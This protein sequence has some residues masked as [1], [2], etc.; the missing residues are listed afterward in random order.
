MLP[1]NHHN[2]QQNPKRVLVKSCFA[3]GDLIFSVKTDPE[4]LKVGDVISFVEGSIVVTH[5]IVEVQSA[6]N[7]TIKWITKGD[8]NNTEDIR[9]VYE[10]NLVGKYVTHIP[11]LGSFALFMQ[12]PLGMILFIGVPLLGFIIYDIIRRQHYANKERQKTADMQA[13]IDRLR[14]LAGE[15]HSSDFEEQ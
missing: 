15:T 5:R 12:T 10:A 3:A 13:E 9:P 14:A 2:R 4:K 11:K 1:Q 7:G 6:E 8:A